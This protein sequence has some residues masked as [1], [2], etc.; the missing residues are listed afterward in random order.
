MQDKNVHNLIYKLQHV[1]QYSI[2]AVKT[3]TELYF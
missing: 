3:T 1:I 2:Y